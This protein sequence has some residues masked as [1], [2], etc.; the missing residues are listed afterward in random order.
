MTN[1]AAVSPLDVLHRDAEHA[2][3]YRIVYGV[4][5]STPQ[6]LASQSE[7][8]I[9]AFAELLA[10]ARN[11]ANKCKACPEIDALQDAI[12]AFGEVG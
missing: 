8:A 7:R 10:A 5:D 9:A 12:A 1:P 2:N 4:I 6:E 3:A 11:A